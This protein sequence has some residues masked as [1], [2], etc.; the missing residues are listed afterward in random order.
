MVQVKNQ[1]EKYRGHIEP[2]WK[3]PTEVEKKM[4]YIKES[5]PKSAE[6]C[7][8]KGAGNMPKICA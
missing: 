4:T 8:Q 3:G 2:T 1:E 6:S 7:T 5:N